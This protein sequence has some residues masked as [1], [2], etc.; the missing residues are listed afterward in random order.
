MFLS[1]LLS[2]LWNVGE[3]RTQEDEQQV[4]SSGEA[5][6][7][8][9]DSLPPTDLRL[10]LIKS[11]QGRLAWVETKQV[12]PIS[13]VFWC[14]VAKPP[15]GWDS[16]QALT[17]LLR[18][19]TAGRA[20]SRDSPESW[21]TMRH[22]QPR[23]SHSNT[24]NPGQANYGMGPKLR[25]LH[26]ILSTDSNTSWSGCRM[27]REKTIT[28]RSFSPLVKLLTSSNTQQKWDLPRDLTEI[29]SFMELCQKHYLGEAANCKCQTPGK[30]FLCS[31]FFVVSLGSGKNFPYNMGYAVSRTFPFW[32]ISLSKFLILDLSEFSLA[33]LIW[34]WSIFLCLYSR[35]NYLTDLNRKASTCSRRHL[36]CGLLISSWT[37]HKYINSVL[38]ECV[39]LK[40]CRP[41]P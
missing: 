20:C 23:Q 40:P 28:S 1:L 3:Q 38:I 18:V 19:S 13:P 9:S 7:F 35:I 8:Y 24:S 6:E 17:S 12:L 11:S 34:F 33:F 4:L 41:K 5:A 30:L 32:T 26:R 25:K 15:V 21:D 16:H 10:K 14:Q 36:L 2:I 37:F 39:E 27:G 22:Q 29:S 31:Q